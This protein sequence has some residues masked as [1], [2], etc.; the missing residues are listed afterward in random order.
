MLKK[1]RKRGAER[2]CLGF[3]ATEGV[4]TNKP[5]TPW[6]PYWCPACDARRRGAITAKFE[7][8]RASL[9]W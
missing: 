6:T 2:R 9:R 4:C 1:R 5:G 3:G 7:A 8:I